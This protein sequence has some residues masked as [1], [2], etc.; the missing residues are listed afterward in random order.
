MQRF[1]YS[2]F[3]FLILGACARVGQ[4][5]GGE[6]DISPP[7]IIKT[8]PANKALNFKGKEIKIH[9]D[10]FIQLKDLNNNLLITPPQK[11]MPEI[12]PMGTAAKEIRVKFKDSLL[13]NTTYVINFGESIQDYNE[14][15]KMNNYQFIFSTGEK[16]D[17]L[18][19][20]GKVKP[21]HFDKTPENIIVGLYPAETFMD[22]LVYRETP[23][24]VAKTDKNGNF[25]LNF[26]KN[27]NYK[28]VA[29]DDEVKNYIYNPNKEAIGFIDSLI[30]IPRDSIINLYLFKES[31]KFKLDKLKQ[32]SKHH[33]QAKY[34][35]NIDSL[36]FKFLSPIVDSIEIL[37]AQ[38]SDIW[39]KSDSDS[40]KIEL[41]SGKYKKLLKEKRTEQK[42]SLV[43]SINALVTLSPLD[44]LIIEGNI[45]IID[46]NKNKIELSR[47]SLPIPFKIVKLPRHRSLLKFDKESEKKYS[48]KL[49]PQAVTDFL[50]NKNIDT[51][52]RK[53]EIAKSQE[54]G[55]LILEI[56]EAKQD[57][58]IELLDSNKK[59]IRKSPTTQA[60][61]V[62]FQ[63][64]KPGKYFVRII[65][66]KNKNNQWDT[67]NYLKH[68]KPENIIDIVSP[69][70][71][72]ANWE[73]NQ[74]ID[75]P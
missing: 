23:Y 51:I 32:I 42:D 46:I 20:K 62:D 48:L 69:I 43:V 64:L 19:L 39:Y 9:F 67:G 25:Q 29:I 57:Y 7:K 70:E 26:L 36:S 17:T 12:T 8:T 75:L 40:L 65:L 11:N 1:F 35:G 71:I 6:K 56:P 59:I 73:V 3:L 10:E 33:I 72:R 47:D 45:P 58:F 54:F 60:S 53:F 15:N 5:T 16:I 41:Q 34:S 74:K 14:G 28:I 27:G 55:R 21:L 2:F 22:S 63:F 66:D 49:Y 37:T 44:S 68:K 31:G 50:G 30:Q 18:Q 52:T 24:Y 61:K 4:P 38:K 13:P